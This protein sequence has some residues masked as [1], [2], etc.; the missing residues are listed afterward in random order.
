M[1]RKIHKHY[2]IWAGCFFIYID[3]APDSPGFAVP[4][5]FRLIRHEKLFA[6]IFC[7]FVEIFIIHHWDI[8]RTFKNFK[9]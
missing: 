4:D 8:F 2:L 1:N 9:E 6:Y 5:I 7:D 3:F